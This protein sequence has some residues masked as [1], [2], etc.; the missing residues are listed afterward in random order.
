MRYTELAAG[1][2]VLTAAV[3]GPDLAASGYLE[4]EYRAE[5]TVV[6]FDASGRACGATEAATRIVVRAPEAPERASGV[7]VVEWLNVSSGNDVAPDY[8]YLAEEIVRRGHAWVGV[9]AQY[10]GVEGGRPSVGEIAGPNGLRHLDPDRYGDL[11][12]PGDAYAYHLFARI[13]ATLDAPGAPLERHEVGRRIAIG[14]SQSAFALT[15]Y[16]GLLPAADAELGV[17]DAYL[18][19]SRGRAGL[20]RG[21]VGAPADLDLLRAGPTALLPEL[22]V[23]VITVQTETDVLSP[24]FAYVDARQPDGPWRRCWEVAGTAH[25][26]RWQVGEFEEFLGCPE[27]VNRGQQV[28]VLRAALRWLERW[29]DDATAPPASEPLAVDDD[30][31]VLDELGNARGGVRTPAVEAPTQVLTGLLGDDV[32]LMCRLFGATRAVPVAS[33]RARHASVEDYLDTY[34]AAV[35]AAI[36]AGFVLA[37]DREA[38][39]AEAR[40]DLVRDAIAHA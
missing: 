10:V 30:R 16:L 1:T 3:T 21:D 28:F 19:H 12:H 14:E 38:L 40:P 27:P 9:S 36:D 23:P 7:V 17:F 2:P 4:A 35:D 34:G 37:E 32:S 15:A 24:R 6:R 20:G 8:T 33:L 39:L 13:A 11:H 25:A 26:D 29:V 22:D 31:F 5:G 18:V